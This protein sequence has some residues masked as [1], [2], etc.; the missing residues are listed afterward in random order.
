[1][2][3]HRLQHKG[4]KAIQE[5]VGHDKVGTFLV[6]MGPFQNVRMVKMRSS[7]VVWAVVRLADPFACNSKHA[8]AC[9]NHIN[10]RDFVD[11]PQSRQ[12]GSRAFT[13]DHDASTRDDLPQ[14]RRS[15]ALHAVA[16]RNPLKGGVESCNRVEIRGSQPLRSIAF[17]RRGSW[18][19]PLVFGPIAVVLCI[20]C[21]SRRLHPFR[22]PSSPRVSRSMVGRGSGSTIPRRPAVGG[23]PDRCAYG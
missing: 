13:R 9:I 10:L 21:R 23:L 15:A 1:M 11:R 22:N 8:D 3:N 4:F 17:E 7:L 14:K 12:E 6:R 18:L 5:K 20:G 16:E 19:H 2:I